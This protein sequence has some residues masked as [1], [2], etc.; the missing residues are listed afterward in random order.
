LTF[1]KNNRPSKLA[2]WILSCIYPDK[3]E[4]TSVG[5]FH[6]EYREVYQSEGFFRAHLWY[7]KQIIK[8][9]PSFIQ[10]KIHWGLIM[11]HNYLKTALRNMRR[12]KWH[13]IINI[14]GLSVGLT[15]C[16]FLL[17]YVR[18]ELSFDSHHKDS[19]RIYRI[20]MTV[21]GT[22]FNNTYAGIAPLFADLFKGTLP[23]IEH[24]TWTWSHN[25]DSQV[26]FGEKIFKEE[27][28]HVL[29]VDEDFLNIFSVKFK[30][31]NPNTA[32]MAPNSA[33]I[34]AEIA[35]K[36][37]DTENALDKVITIDGIDY[38]ITGIIEDPPG[39]S[40]FQQKIIKSWNVLEAPLG[41][42]EQSAGFGG[43]YSTFVKFK[44]G[45]DI[46]EFR[47]QIKSIIIERNR[48]YLES[49]Q[50][51]V[52]VT[53]QPLRDIHFQPDIQFDLPAAGN[54][55]YIYLF[56]GIALFILLITLV[57]FINLSTSCSANR[58]GEVGIRKTVGAQR[59]QL[60]VQFMGESYLTV[61]VS[62][63]IALVMV[64]LLIPQFNAVMSTRLEYSVLF[65]KDVLMGLMVLFVLEG[66]VAGI[67]P[68]FFLSSFKPASVLRGGMKNKM[69][70]GN[71]RRILV[72]V[73]FSVSIILIVISI[74]FNLQL[75]YMKNKPLGFE[76]EQMLIVDFQRHNYKYDP[77][78]VKQEFLK[79]PSVVGA[80]FSSSIPGRWLYPWDVW[81]TGQRKTNTHYI[82]AMG[83]DKDFLALYKIDLVAGDKFDTRHGPRS[84]ILSEKA[85]HTFG[86]DSPEDALNTTILDEWEVIGVMKDFHF[87][88]LQKTIEPVGFFQ[89]PLGSYLSLKLNTK[90]IGETLAFIEN[91]YRALFPGKYLEYFFLDDDFNRHYLKEEQIKK[92]FNIFTFLGIFIACLGLLALSA[93]MAEQKTKEI[94]I[95]KILGASTASITYILAIGFVKWVVISITIA[96]PVSYV[97]VNKVLQNFAYRI[98]IKIWMFMISALASLAIALLTVSYQTIKAATADPVKSLRYE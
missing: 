44:P 43:F 14:F 61:A 89:T 36:Y 58:A 42:S 26:E 80:S 33:I 49:S 4:F 60:V 17:L 48:D 29:S 45:I 47:N 55:L 34:T 71:L 28:K 22:T 88:G 57:N 75:H 82:H 87:T 20:M 7:W 72:I 63:V 65:Q 66:M 50:A 38:R 18:Y 41:P 62:Y 2:E 59:R 84:W 32:L 1:K 3:G 85:L 23:Q 37:F 19:G 39:N 27:S 52:A 83:V 31:G 12:N 16:M 93:F 70:S 9:I 67:Y 69:K 6:E 96:F 11:I 35:R 13:S 40:I 8:S 30:L 77:L 91:K 15:I 90:N 92:I 79:H 10:N 74:V 81:P 53:L 24:I 68:A 21:E 78:S 64:N 76:K 86:W 51:D 73:Q 46:E 95:R 25:V 56:A 5:D 98:D 54:V 94:G 97:I